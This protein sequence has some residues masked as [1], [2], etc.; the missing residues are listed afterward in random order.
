[1]CAYCVCV[2]AATVLNAGEYIDE[3]QVIN[4]RAECELYSSCE[5]SNAADDNTEHLQLGCRGVTRNSGA[6]GQNI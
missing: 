2:L 4:K 6:P 3:T 1:M 5:V